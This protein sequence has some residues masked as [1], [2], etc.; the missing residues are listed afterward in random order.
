MI[1]FIYAK[2]K[3][4]ILEGFSSVSYGWNAVTVSQRVPMKQQ[5][6]L[7][8]NSYTKMI[9]KNNKKLVVLKV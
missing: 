5:K 2:R 8:H 4:T 1:P 7:F 3:K 9:A 6:K